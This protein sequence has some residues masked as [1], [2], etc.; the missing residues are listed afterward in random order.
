MHEW[1]D[2][3]ICF[4]PHALIGSVKAIQFVLSQEVRNMT[5]HDQFMILAVSGEL[6]LDIILEQLL[7]FGARVRSQH[8]SDFPEVKQGLSRSHQFLEPS[9][10]RLNLLAQNKLIDLRVQVTT[11]NSCELLEQ[12]S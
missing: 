2:D 4:V 10:A 11:G 5:A 1:K 7:Q 12:S 8:G 3:V 9:E 6:P